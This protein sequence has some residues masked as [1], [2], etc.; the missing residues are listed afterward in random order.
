MEREAKGIP[1]GWQSIQDDRGATFTQRRAIPH[2]TEA[3]RRDV[4]RADK[5]EEEIDR[6]TDLTVQE[7]E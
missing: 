1:R 2:W 5:D 4:S 7:F 3:P 6:L